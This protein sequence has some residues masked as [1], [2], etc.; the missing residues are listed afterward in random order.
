[1]MSWSLNLA[2]PSPREVASQEHLL[3]Q[4]PFIQHG[5]GDAWLPKSIVFGAQISALNLTGG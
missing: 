2:V 3:P 1:M 4:L 5:K